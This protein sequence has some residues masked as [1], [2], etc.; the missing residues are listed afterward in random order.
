MV[1]LN[2]KI[3][4]RE[5]PYLVVVEVDGVKLRVVIEAESGQNALECAVDHFRKKRC[6][7]HVVGKSFEKF[8]KR[9]HRMCECLKWERKQ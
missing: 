5:E 4:D 1:C 8:D 3:T 9:M 7:C 6:T 2:D